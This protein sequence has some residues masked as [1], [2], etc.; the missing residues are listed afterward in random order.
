MAL[1]LLPLSV[2]GRGLGGGVVLVLLKRKDCLVT[3]HSS[4]CNKLPPRMFFLPG[5]AEVVL[6]QLWAD[7]TLPAR[8]T[9]TVAEA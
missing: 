2:A 3:V 1:G 6:R 9:D 5:I 8:R 7:L 4:R